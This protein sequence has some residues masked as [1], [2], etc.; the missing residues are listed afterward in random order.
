MKDVN[1]STPL[2]G[3]TGGG[4][5]AVKVHEVTPTTLAFIFLS[6]LVTPMF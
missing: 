6:V 4:G 1:P 5:R 3:F 2:V